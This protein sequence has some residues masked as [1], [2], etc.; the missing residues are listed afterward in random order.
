MAVVLRQMQYQFK[1]L[2]VISIVIWVYAFVLLVLFCFTY[3][4]RIVLYPWSVAR[5]LRASILETACLSAVSTA[6]TAVI[7]MAMLVLVPAWGPTWS[8]IVYVL[9]WINAALAVSILILIHYFHIRIQPPGRPTLSPTILLPPLAA[10]TAAVGGGTLCVYGRIN[11]RLQVPVIIVSYL[12]TGAG[13]PLA[14]ATVKII[15]SRL[16]DRYF[17]SPDVIHEEA[18]LCGPFAQGAS[19]M[20]L[21]GEAVKNGAFA[22]YNE[23]SFLT[24]RKL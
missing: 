9:W 4:L 8:I 5:I 10:L 7:T 1:G 6:Y 17:A 20:M 21:L 19:A 11:E 15:R 16:Y 2:G 14:F 3:L 18:I 13:F 12:I 22:K 24:E 23:G